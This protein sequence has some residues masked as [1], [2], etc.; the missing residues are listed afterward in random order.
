MAQPPLEY[1]DP[2][3]LPSWY[4]GIMSRKNAEAV[5][6]ASKLEPGLFL[7]RAS[8]QKPGYVLS[9]IFEG[10]VVHYQIRQESTAD[11]DA[12]LTFDTDTGDAPRFRSLSSVLHHL[13]RNPAHLPVPLSRWVERDDELIPPAP[14]PR[15]SLQPA[16]QAQGAGTAAAVTAAA[17]VPAAKAP[18]LS[19][20]A[21]I[22]LPEE[23]EAQRK[24]SNR[25]D[26]RYVE[27]S[28]RQRHNTVT[29]D[30]ATFV[31][32]T[33]VAANAPDSSLTREHLY[34]TVQENVAELKK[35]PT[36]N[37]LSAPEGGINVR[38]AR[39]GQELQLYANA[40]LS[41]V[42]MTRDAT[43]T[44]VVVCRDNEGRLLHIPMDSDI[45][46]VPSDIAG[47]SRTPSIRIEEDHFRGMVDSMRE[48][49][50][51][52]KSTNTRPANK[53]HNAA[54]RASRQASLAEMVRDSGGLLPL[55]S[56]SDSDEHEF[57]R[58]VIR[59]GYL[60]KLPPA[61]NRIQAWRRRYFRLAIA[62]NRSMA[63]GPVFLEYYGDHNKKRPKGVI[64]LDHVVRIGRPS[65][66]TLER[67]SVKAYRN[68]PHENIF[69][70]E[71]PK[72]SYRVMAGSEVERDDWI[73]TLREIMGMTSTLPEPEELK[74]GETIP[75]KFHGNVLSRTVNNADG[76][77]LLNDDS[78]TLSC[79]QTDE[80][81]TTWYFK[82][83]RGFGYIRNVCWVEAGRAC[84][85]GAGIFCFS[86][87]KAELMFDSLNRLMAS[88]SASGLGRRR[89]SRRHN[90][91]WTSLGESMHTEVL[92]DEPHRVIEGPKTVFGIVIPP[93]D[94]EPVAVAVPRSAYSSAKPNEFSFD[95]SETMRIL[96][97]RAF[98]DQGYWLA[99]KARQEDFGLVPRDKVEVHEHEFGNLRDMDDFGGS[100]DSLMADL[101]VATFA[102]PDEDKL[103]TDGDR[104]LTADT[105]ETAADAT[106]D[107]PKS[108][109]QQATAAAAAAGGGSGGNDADESP[110]DE[111]IPP[112]Q[113]RD[114]GDLDDAAG[115]GY[116]NDK[117]RGH[118]GPLASA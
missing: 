94:L 103:T 52:F 35:A 54:R 98:F 50:F 53:K 101:D 6:L 90:L 93:E 105:S 91:S 10:R 16:S 12:Y 65:K 72:R 95:E 25:S 19:G 116:V 9:L 48:E 37:V 31:R 80:E 73:A 86:T 114:V 89:L 106:Y 23:S 102:Y 69:E 74:P 39:T 41:L 104:R 113:R 5:L 21:E 112:S 7:L 22:G 88:T 68:V 61:R 47:P 92:D 110:Y 40:T 109:A 30:L 107:T 66:A 83:L 85:T 99:Q 71:M 24:G 67:G 13:F 11:G 108:A 63:G 15:R 84:P 44:E 4:H 97:S 81:V 36:V 45:E 64:D 32:D 79:P 26:P 78:L 96:A 29:S 87:K 1:P 115:K 58:D 82:H 62:L 76:T 57:F 70:I 27:P 33:M 20:D 8:M 60:S 38:D 49:D 46:V 55:S 3:G 18:A 117:V 34:A 51:G 77:V 56:G 118:H 43:D 75:R 111:P 14:A 59:Q 17:A 42:S 2:R 28:A 100:Q